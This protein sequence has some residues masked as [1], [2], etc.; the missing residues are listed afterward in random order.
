MP[1]DKP[2][3]V[4]KDM[5]TTLFASEDVAPLGTNAGGKPV[6]GKPKTD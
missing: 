6:K 5:G 4:K 3:I 1:E 2:K